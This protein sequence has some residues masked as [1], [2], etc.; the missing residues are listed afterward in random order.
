MTVEAS[1]REMV[2]HQSLPRFSGSANVT[3]L[4]SFWSALETPTHFKDYE[5]HLSCPW[6]FLLYL[7]ILVP[8]LRSVRRSQSCGL[9]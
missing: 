4:A 3:C 2:D 6:N 1:G 8:P 9:A 5:A 7:L